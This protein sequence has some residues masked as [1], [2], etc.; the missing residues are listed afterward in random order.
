MR[1]HLAAV[2][3]TLEV[4]PHALRRVQGKHHQDHYWQDALAVPA[5]SSTGI[6]FRRQQRKQQ[7]QKNRRQVSAGSKSIAVASDLREDDV[8][9]VLRNVKNKRYVS[10]D[11]IECD[12]SQQHNGGEPDVGILACGGANFY[13]VESLDSSLGGYCAETQILL[14]ESRRSLQ[15][16]NAT[17]FCS[18]CDCSGLVKGVGA[19]ENCPYYSY[20]CLP[21]ATNNT[22]G[23]NVICSAVFASATFSSP[24][25]L[26]DLKFCYDLKKP[27]TSEMCYAYSYN[28]AGNATTC[29]ISANGTA[30]TSCNITTCH[31]TQAAIFDCTNT[32]LGTKG[33]SCNQDYAFPWISQLQSN[34]MFPGGSFAPTPSASIQ[35]S[36]KPSDMTMVADTPS[37]TPSKVPFHSPGGNIAAAPSP[38]PT[39]LDS[40]ARAPLSGVAKGTLA[41][42]SATNRAPRNTSGVRTIGFAATAVAVAAASFFASA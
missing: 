37:D 30:C 31:G 25:Q 26:S 22:F 19:V 32:V 18:K 11:V 23:S 39:R 40:P 5:E 24:Q 8:G 20:D 21:L 6:F 35:A 2:A 33:N 3:L 16:V 7:Q 14:H 1:L 10:N 15:L 13:C 27:Y 9:S 34:T 42:S 41:P 28:S 4:S 38:L 29:L 36:D 17:E 12:P